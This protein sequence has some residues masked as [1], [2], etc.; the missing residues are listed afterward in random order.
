MVE[1]GRRTNRGAASV[2][3]ALFLA[4]LALRPDIIGVGPILED[5]R[6]DLDASR[7]VIGLLPTVPVL[8]MGLFAPLGGRVAA[9]IGARSGVLVGLLLI[10]GAARVF[11]S[12]RRGRRQQLRTDD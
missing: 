3:I 6:T 12:F 1:P 2:L 11:A 8:C 5:I 9:R 10:A 4:A 7:T